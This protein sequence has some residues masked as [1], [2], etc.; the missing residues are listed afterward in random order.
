LWKAK[1]KINNEVL[2][3]A[4]RVSN[5]TDNSG[6]SIYRDPWKCGGELEQKLIE[7][8]EAGRLWALFTGLMPFQLNGEKRF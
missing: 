4:M 3:E 6:N 8:G 7:E 5:E 2:R 1:K